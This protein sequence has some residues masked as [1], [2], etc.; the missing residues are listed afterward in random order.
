MTMDKTDDTPTVREAV[1]VFHDERT[2]QAAADDLLIA[3]FDRAELNL[4]AGHRA[5][6]E[7][8][9][10]AYRRVAELE[11]EAPVASRFYASSSSRT[12]AQGAIVGGLTYVGAVAATGMIVASGGTLAGVLAG[13]ALAGGAGGLV[14]VIVARFIDRRH[15]R[16]LQDHLDHGGLLLWVHV[17]DADLEERA[18]EVLRRHSAE[19][20]HVMTLPRAHFSDTG[21]VS[22]DLSFMKK[23][24]M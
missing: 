20:V 9:G 16:Y 10:H 24:G 19:D 14:G 1:G 22:L 18:V 12:E 4:L 11:D 5:I 8:L 2:L 6:E 23:L 17:A 13:I 7:R 3:G 21:G 15:A